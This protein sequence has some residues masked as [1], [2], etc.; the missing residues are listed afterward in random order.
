MTDYRGV[1]LCKLCR[2][3]TRAADQICDRHPKSRQAAAGDE[4]RAR[5]RC[6]QG[7]HDDPDNSGMCI[8]CKVILDPELGDD[9]NEYRRR[10]GLPD[11]PVEPS[12]R[13]IR[14]RRK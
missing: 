1:R 10:R 5:L 4:P 2:R 3:P 13:R 12:S 8:R 14:P 7:W 11:V 9:P 6:A